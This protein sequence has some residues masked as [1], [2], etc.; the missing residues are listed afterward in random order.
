MPPFVKFALKELL[1]LSGT[2]DLAAKTVLQQLAK[3]GRTWQKLSTRMSLWL[4]DHSSS[5]CVIRFVAHS[6]PQVRRL[7]PIGGNGG[8]LARDAQL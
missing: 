5:G 8:Y 7:L 2:G 6:P 4:C 1:E 3:V